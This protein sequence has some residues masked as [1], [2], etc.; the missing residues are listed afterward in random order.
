VPFTDKEW[1]NLLDGCPTDESG[2]ITS[3]WSSA[4]TVFM[5]L[6]SL[7]HLRAERPV[8]PTAPHSPEGA[9]DHPHAVSAQAPPGRAPAHAW[10]CEVGFIRWTDD[11]LAMFQ[12]CSVSINLLEYFVAALFI[13][14]WVD[15]LE[16]QVVEVVV[17][18]TTA[19]S[20][21]AKDRGGGAM[22]E[23]FVII[24]TIFCYKHGVV[25][26]PFHVAGVDNLFADRLSRD[27]SLQE[28]YEPTAIPTG[29]SNRTLPSLRL[30]TARHILT[31]LSEWPSIMP[32]HRL[33][34]IVALL[35]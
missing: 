34:E 14:G 4:T 28:T 33:L 24:M 7:P 20:W 25:T 12:R 32:L 10:C 1:E 19:V 9:R 29:A 21:F 5:P 15:S 30:S 26:R 8:Q 6:D 31:T 3:Y 22:A 2:T 17:D 13:I 23:N 27:I 16:G 35:D 18:N 11:E